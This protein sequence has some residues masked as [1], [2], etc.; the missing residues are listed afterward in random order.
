MNAL[1]ATGESRQRGV[2]LVELMIA[3]TIGLIIGG[4]VLGVYVNA[5]RNFAQDERFAR[6]QENGRYA[7]RALSEDLTMG[8][9]WGKVVSTDTVTTSLS[10]TSGNCGVGVDLYNADSA[11]MFN[12]YHSAPVTTQFTPCTAITSTQQ[13]GTDI[14]AIK[15]VAGTATAST[16]VD[17][18]DVDA[19]SDTSEV[20]T[21]GASSLH[22]GTVYL[23]SNSTNAQFINNAS[24]GN[25]PASGESDWSYLPRVYYVRDY[26]DDPGDGI[27]SLCRLDISGTGLG[28]PS[29]LAEGI[30]DVHVEFGLDSDLDGVA[31]RYTSTPTLAEMESVVSARIHVLAR[32]SEVAPFYT[33]TKVYNL[34]DATIAAAN[35]G[36][37]RAVFSTTVS[38]RNSLN[39]NILN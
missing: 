27:P 25:P 3:M 30:E 13:P 21:T 33:D 15:R 11:L 7:L 1:T 24:S 9:F 36:Y 5:A 35:D 31:N 16:F 6:M 12:N 29:C 28:T 39:R 34:G 19:D 14:I 23:R 18:T 38:I 10:V 32:T 17:A 26:Y 37:L 20:I 2:S 22:N 8:D 4:A